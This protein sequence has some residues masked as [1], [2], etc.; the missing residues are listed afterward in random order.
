VF[1]GKVQ[2]SNTEQRSYHVVDETLPGGGGLQ[3]QQGGQPAVLLHNDA[4]H[5]QQPGDVGALGGDGDGQR[6]QEDSG[7][8]PG[9]RKQGSTGGSPRGEPVLSL[10]RRAPYL[11]ISSWVRFLRIS[12]ERW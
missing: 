12:L 6:G 2:T 11:C 9:A 4:V 7:G 5:V 1:R 3:A 10:R 8:H